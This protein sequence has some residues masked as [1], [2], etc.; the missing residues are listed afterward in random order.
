MIPQYDMIV[1]M[2]CT[3]ENKKPYYYGYMNSDF[4]KAQWD[5]MSYYGGFQR[6]EGLPEH[7]CPDCLE[8]L[9]E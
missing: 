8:D 6:S 9:Y 5:G 3:H 4:V 1:Y 7:F 2:E